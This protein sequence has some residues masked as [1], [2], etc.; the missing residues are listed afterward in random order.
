MSPPVTV[1]PSPAIPAAGKMLLDVF[2]YRDVRLLP[3]RFLTQ[4]EQAR[5]FYGGLSNDSI[6]KGFRRQAGLPA[7]GEDMK[8]WASATCAGIFGQL[9]SGMVRLGKAT[10]DTALCQKAVA[11]F[12]GWL[13]TMPADGNAHMRTYDWD[14]LV[15][16]LVDLHCH[17]GIE[18][19]MPI[20]RAT[21]DW[22]AGTFDKSRPLA[23]DHDFWGAGP[24]L[25]S[26]WY[27]L[28]ENLYRAYL[29]SGDAAFKSF[30]DIWL[31]HDY[32]EPFARSAE[33]EE[34][35]TVHAYSHV[36]SFSS[37]AAA[38]Q[39]TGDERYL[40]ICRN[41]YDFLQRTQVYA[42]G[43]YGPDE[44]LM[45][46]DGSLGRSLDCC[47]Y[48]AEIPCGA[49]AAFKL[50]RYLMAF[51]GEA[52]FGDWIET[53]LLN[54]L[55]GCLP[56]QPD[57]KAFYYGDYRISGGTKQ[58]Y[59]HE[60]PCCSGT[61][62]QL[63]AEYHNLIY[64]KDDA[65]IYVN[66]YMP[67]ELHWRQG[68]HAVTLRQETAYPERPDST[69]TLELAEPARFAL[70]F[71]IPSWAK[72]A[73]LSL[74]GA[75]LEVE[76]KPGDWASLEREWA[77]GDRVTVNLPM[78]LRVVPVDAQHPSRAAIVYGPV[79]L[80]QDEACC[81]RPLTMAPHTALEKR[82][83]KEGERL[84]FRIING[85]PE[86]HTRYLLPLYDFPAN[87]PYFVYFD[88]HAPTLY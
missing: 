81:R 8:G 18:A 4:V 77:Q 10:G 48:H 83:V 9:V 3:G 72:D 13:E 11:L 42:T 44:R 1:A 57:G 7:P 5:S 21:T 19:A 66:L 84:S 32:W 27:T 86:R 82:L 43:G 70:R 35:H 56:P 55:A 68:E 17:L 75:A 23:D 36:N 76:A 37:A 14:K 85:V 62:I 51:T 2:D 39:V 38:Y 46:A 69:V 24:G 26:E 34:I 31:Y 74:N 47:G 58:F 41:A 87:W 25:T 59:W 28:P 71:R 63:M 78:A 64:F 88:L 65:G 30:A 33:I 54:A 52:R 29:A 20:L 53:T 40:R 61:Y 73:S 49:W 16:G 12:E 60:W 80:A 79:V 22:A 15:C 50:S 6:L 45:R 67:S